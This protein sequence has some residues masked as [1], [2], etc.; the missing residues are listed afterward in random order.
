MAYILLRCPD[1]H[2][3]HIRK[4]QQIPA[5]CPVCGKP[6]TYLKEVHDEKETKQRPKGKTP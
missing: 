2:L 3:V 1:G 6:L 4:G 5:F